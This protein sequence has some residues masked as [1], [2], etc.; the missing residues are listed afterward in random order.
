MFVSDVLDSTLP[1]WYH[2]GY[3]LSST[4]SSARKICNTVCP[5]CVIMHTSQCIITGQSRAGILLSYV[6]WT[7]NMGRPFWFVDA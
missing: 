4:P 3:A 7:F 5:D 6:T 2:L 1:V